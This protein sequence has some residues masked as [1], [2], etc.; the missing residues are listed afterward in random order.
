M[1]LR[2]ASESAGIKCRGL[3]PPHTYTHYL[4]P[5]QTSAACLLYPL[6]VPW[7]LLSL[8]SYHSLECT[9]S[10]ASGAGGASQIHIYASKSMTRVAQEDTESESH[11]VRTAL[12]QTSP[13]SHA[14]RH[15]GGRIHIHTEKVS[16]ETKQELVSPRCPSLIL[17]DSIVLK[18]TTD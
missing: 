14:Q 13:A 2:C 6:P 11:S 15:R 7:T 9:Y 10:G 12:Q 18:K 3:S 1:V 8:G 4:Q 5:T 17:M 16:T